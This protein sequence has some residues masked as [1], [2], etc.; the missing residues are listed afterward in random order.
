MN[1]FQLW[2]RAQ[3]PAIRALLTVNVVVYLL[4]RIVFVHI[5]ATRGFFWEYLALNPGLSD[6]LFKPWQLITYNFLHLSNGLGGLLH[7]LFNMLWLVWIGRDYE[8]MQGSHRLLAI[9]LIGGMGGGLLTVLLHALFPGVAVFGGPVHGASASVLGVMMAVA[10]TYPQK[11]I[12]LLF[13]GTFRLIHVVIG[14][15]VLDLLF[16]A[17]GGTSI[18]AHL[19][20]ALFGLLFAKGEA[21]GMDLSS[22]TGFVFQRRGGGRRRSSPGGRSASGG[23]GWL[24]RMEGWLASREERKEEPRQREATIH[25]M[26]GRK[27]PEAAPPSFEAEVDRILD[28]I[29]AQGYDALTAEERRVLEEASDRMK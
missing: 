1:R 9:Y 22:W 2:Y 14:F 15:L 29:S 17:G 21:G 8:Q 3:P 24:S 6:I 10:I 20:G 18:S 26:P 25:P 4:W 7:I 28:K 16:L 19:G 23:D 5:A 13:L 27:Q 12:G 11:S